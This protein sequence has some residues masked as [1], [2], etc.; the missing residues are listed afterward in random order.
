MAKAKAKAKAK[1]RALNKTGPADTAS[2]DVTQ[3]VPYLINRATNGLMDRF[4]DGLKPHGLSL[5]MWRVIA[6]LFAKGPLRFSALTTLC[7]LEPASASR[8]INQ[9]LE[10]ELISKRRSATDARGV[11]IEISERGR[12][13]VKAIIP[14]A[15]AVQN[16][17]L[18]DFSED[19]IYLVRRLL[20]R[21]CDNIAPLSG[22]GE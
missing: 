3:Y 2:F 20:Q 22:S 5:S 17:T 18:K 8:F 6:M 13:I 1:T 21:L 4:T 14:H 19:E 12:G 15:I 7:S 9:L 16:A 11:V 10:L